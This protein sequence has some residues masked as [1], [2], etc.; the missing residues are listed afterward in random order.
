MGRN[1][2]NRQ[3]QLQAARRAR[4]GRSQI[5]S[6]HRFDNISDGHREILIASGSGEVMTG[7]SMDAA[8]VA[9]SEDEE[10]DGT[11]VCTWPGGVNNHIEDEDDWIDL[12]EDFGT[13][14]RV[15]LD[16]QSGS[17]SGS[18]SEDSDEELQELGGEELLKSLEDQIIQEAEANLTAYRNLSRAIPKQEWERAEANRKLGY[19]KQSKRTKRRKRQEEKAKVQEAETS[20]K[21]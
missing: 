7:D 14:L 19:N 15:G 17:G 10:D 11:Q 20:R 1:S 6:S 21:G 13:D 18:G 16:V 12:S 2:K 8:M 9:D 5:R 3:N 4:S